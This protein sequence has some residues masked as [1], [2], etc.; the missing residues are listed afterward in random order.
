VDL[1][2]R[3][4]EK[5]TMKHKHMKTTGD[6]PWQLTRFPHGLRRRLT[7]QAVLEGR[8]VHELA[9]AAVKMYLSTLEGVGREA[10]SD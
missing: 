2:A 7:S 10:S 4:R 6:G 1:A 3:P 8:P 5:D 9:I